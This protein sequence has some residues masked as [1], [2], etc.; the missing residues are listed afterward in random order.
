[1]QCGLLSSCMFLEMQISPRSI[2][3]LDEHSKVYKAVELINSRC[4]LSCGLHRLC[5]HIY[6]LVATSVITCLKLCVLVLIYTWLVVLGYSY[7]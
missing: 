3:Q 1:M 7:S 2:R 5:M 4:S 6:L